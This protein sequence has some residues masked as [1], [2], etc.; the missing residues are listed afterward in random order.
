MKKLLLLSIALI[1]ISGSIAKTIKV[2]I[3][4]LRKS[5]ADHAKSENQSWDLLKEL[6]QRV[7]QVENRYI[8]YTLA[9]EDTMDEDKY[10]Y[11]DYDQQDDDTE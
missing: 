7:S 4:E 2:K 9:S 6:D 11:P 3:T 5:I 8:G 10:I 1:T